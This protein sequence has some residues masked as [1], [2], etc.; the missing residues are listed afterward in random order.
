MDKIIIKDH[1]KCETLDGF[2]LGRVSAI[3]SPSI[4]KK[5]ILYTTTR[6]YT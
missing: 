4:L 6:V 2:E 1:G 3:Y 5:F